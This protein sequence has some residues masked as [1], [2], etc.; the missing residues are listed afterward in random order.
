MFSFALPMGLLP[1]V[2]PFMICNETSR[3][4]A[5]DFYDGVFVIWS[6]HFL[7]C[8]S[9]ASFHCFTPH[10]PKPLHGLNSWINLPFLILLSDDVGIILSYFD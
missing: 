9:F 1:F 4:I 10:F 8:K 3:A 6:K 7:G 2:F 5:F